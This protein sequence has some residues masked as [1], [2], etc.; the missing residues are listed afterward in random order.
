MQTTIEIDNRLLD[1]ARVVTG[2]EETSALIHAGL[3]A[4]IQR[5]N[6]GLSTH[7]IS[8]YRA[9]EDEAFDSPAEKE[10]RQQQAAEALAAMRALQGKIY[11][12]RKLTRDEMNER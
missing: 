9:H 10:R 8:H 1:R 6:S 4:L 11:I 12:G 3:D 5:R 2:V 7:S